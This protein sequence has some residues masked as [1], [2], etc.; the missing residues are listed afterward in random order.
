MNGKFNFSQKERVWGNDQVKCQQMKMSENSMN[1]PATLAHISLVYYSTVIETKFAVRNHGPLAKYV[2]LRVA[3]PPWTS[4]TFSPS[5]ISKETA[6]WRSRHAPR[7]VRPARAVMH[8]GI[9]NPRWR[10]IRSRH[11]RRMRNP[12]IYI[13]GMRPIRP[14]LMKECDVCTTVLDTRRFSYI[15]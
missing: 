9:V 4:G 10:G 6:C 15:P 2:K 14:F 11:S 8:V 12:Q 3:H 5:P 7:H 13:S 1:M